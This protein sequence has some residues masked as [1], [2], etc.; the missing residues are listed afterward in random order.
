MST[1][2]KATKEW[3]DAL[4]VTARANVAAFI[5]QNFSS[6]ETKADA[7]RAMSAFIQEQ[8]KLG[9]ESKDLQAQAEYF[10]TVIEAKAFYKRLVASRAF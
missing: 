3:L 2:V 9:E 4:V 7:V 5:D 10:S 1:D 8:R 6:Y